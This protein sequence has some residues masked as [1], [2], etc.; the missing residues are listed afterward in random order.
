MVV[1]LPVQV[2]VGL[3]ATKAPMA[4]LRLDDRIY[5][6]F[7]AKVSHHWGW[8]A[9]VL[10]SKLTDISLR[11]LNWPVP[12]VSLFCCYYYYQLKIN[13]KIIVSMA[14]HGNTFKLLLGRSVA[15]HVHSHEHMLEESGDIWREQLA[16]VSKDFLH[17]TMVNSENA[18]NLTTATKGQAFQSLFEDVCSSSSSWLAAAA[19]PRVYSGWAPCGSQRTYGICL[20]ASY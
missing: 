19:A 16:D 12:V 2:S 7:H 3:S 9:P 18:L 5:K 14:P 15:L 8:E 10:I 4:L 13:F 17:R 6:S 1:K 20:P 11:N